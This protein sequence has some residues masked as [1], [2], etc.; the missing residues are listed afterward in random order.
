V[1]SSTWS[2]LFFA[3][4]SRGPWD[5]PRVPEGEVV[6]APSDQIKFLIE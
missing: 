5:G 1:D 2:T 6:I 3:Q 4:N